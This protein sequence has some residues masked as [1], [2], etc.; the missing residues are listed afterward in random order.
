M[1]V[2]LTVDGSDVADA[3]RSTA[4]SDGAFVATV[5]MSSD[6][7][8]DRLVLDLDDTTIAGDGSDA[9]RFTFRALDAYGNQRPYVGGECGSSSA[10]PAC[11]SAR[12]RSPSGPTAASAARSFG[13]WRERP[14][15]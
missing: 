3:A 7:S 12:I 4:T 6:P 8:T 5:Q 1:F 11:S 13:P 14:G 9:T 2:D 10:D 15:S